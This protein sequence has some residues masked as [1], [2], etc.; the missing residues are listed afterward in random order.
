[1][2]LASGSRTRERTGGSCRLCMH[3]CVRASVR[4][5]AVQVLEK[6]APPG[7]SRAGSAV[8]IPASEIAL[9]WEGELC[10]NLVDVSRLDAI[11]AEY[12]D[13]IDSR[14]LR[15]GRIAPLD[16]H[17]KARC[18]VCRWAASLCRIDSRTPCLW[19]SSA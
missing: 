6:L 17:V 4:L 14:C 16:A 11:R 7:A 1:M 9:D 2:K 15:E 3:A 19:F 13:G 5:A 10:S 8:E 12:F 18:C